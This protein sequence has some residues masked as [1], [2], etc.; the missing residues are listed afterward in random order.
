MTLYSAYSKR[1]S[2]VAQL[3]LLTGEPAWGPELLVSIGA[4]GR[5]SPSADV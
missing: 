5:C 1:E 2:S 4:L 3:G